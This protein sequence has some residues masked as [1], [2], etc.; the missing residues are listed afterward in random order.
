MVLGS[1]AGVKEQ[2]AWLCV[3]RGEAC[4]APF[5]QPPESR[6]DPGA[7][8]VDAGMPS[9]G[10]HIDSEVSTPH[11]ICSW[12]EDRSRTAMTSWPEVNSASE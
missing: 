5:F 1:R 12:V 9:G 11:R 7:G 2:A 3:C 10:R 4:A 8:W 6:E